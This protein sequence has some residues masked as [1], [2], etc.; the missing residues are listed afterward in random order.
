MLSKWAARDLSP[1]ACSVC[2]ELAFIPTYRTSGILVAVMLLL[3]AIALAAVATQSYLVGALGL[4]G[5]LAF[6]IWRMRAARLERTWRPH[7]VVGAK[8]GLV[9]SAS[10]AL[11]SFF[12]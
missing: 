5:V 10:A 2:G 1:V 7:T 8:A 9:V 11:M 6:Y 4:V 12:Q 3:T